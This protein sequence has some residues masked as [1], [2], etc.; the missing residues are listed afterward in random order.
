MTGRAC[1][2]CDFQKIG[3]VTFLGDCRWFAVHRGQPEKPIPPAVVDV[4][5]KFWA[6]RQAKAARL[7]FQ[8]DNETLT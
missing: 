8:A 6:A 7:D 2:T 1:W 3:G 5:C 4:G